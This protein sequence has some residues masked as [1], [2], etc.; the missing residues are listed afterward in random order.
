VVVHPGA[1]EPGLAEQVH[2]LVV[3]ELAGNLPPAAPT[4]PLPLPVPAA[5]V[6]HAAGP[7]VARRPAAP[8]VRADRPAER[9]PR[10]APPVDVHRV[11]D[12]VSRRLAR[13]GAVDAERR[14]MSR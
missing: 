13:R 1:R 12:A 8:V 10:A 14:G 7:Q 6:P 9:T 3:R 11:A 5:P 2:R 4:P